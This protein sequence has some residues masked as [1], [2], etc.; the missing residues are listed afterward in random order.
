[1]RP[2]AIVALP[3]GTRAELEPGDLIGRHWGSAL[4]ISDP[5]VSEAHAMVSLRG[6]GLWLLALRGRFAIDGRP[7]TR[8][9]LHV[10]L[11]VLLAPDLPMRIEHVEL[12]AE[13]LALQHPAFGEQLLSRVLSL[14]LHPRPKLANGHRVDADAWFWSDGADWIAGIGDDRIVLEAGEEL[15]VGDQVFQVARRT[16]ST[17]GG[18]A[19]V[20]SGGVWSPMRI[21]ARYDT[22]QLHREGEPIVQLTGQ[23]ARLLSEAATI[24][25]P[26]PWE[27]IAAEIWPDCTEPHRLRR[28]WDTVLG[29]LRRLLRGHGIR[30][31]LVRSGGNGMAELV[32]STHDVLVDET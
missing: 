2:H 22:V 10:G 23:V 7:A 29:R 25:Q 20:A 17:A 15:R 13:V 18:A 1:M 27:V 5:R 4:A 16:L 31:D 9:P 11:E 3:D 24:G 32:L 26:V 8:T 30:D 21:V 19:T 28:R 6:A 12:P 14:H